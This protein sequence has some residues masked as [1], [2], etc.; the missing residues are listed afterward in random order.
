[1]SRQLSILAL[2]ALC[3]SVVGFESSASAQDLEVSG[4]CPGEVTFTISGW[5]REESV[6]VVLSTAPGSLRIPAS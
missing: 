6:T 5:A 1:M 3:L 4:T 2:L